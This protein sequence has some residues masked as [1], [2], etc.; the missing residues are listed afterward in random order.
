MIKFSNFKRA[1]TCSPGLYFNTYENT[2][3][4]DSEKDVDFDLDDKLKFYDITDPDD[5][6]ATVP[7]SYL[8]S[9]D[10]VYVEFLQKMN[11]FLQEYLQP[12]RVYWIKSKSLEDKINETKRIYESD[13]YD[14][15]VN[16]A[17]MDN[18]CVA[19]I[20]A[21]DI[22]NMIMYNE[23]Y[24][25]APLRK[26]ALKAYYNWNILSNWLKKYSKVLKSV[27]FVCR[28]EME[29]YEKEKY[30]FHVIEHVLPNKTR[31]DKTRIVSALG[32]KNFRN[33]EHYK[34]FPE[35][36]I[37]DMFQRNMLLDIVLEKG[38]EPSSDLDANANNFTLFKLKDGIQL[39]HFNQ[40]IQSIKA[41][42]NTKF[43][44]EDYR[45][46]PY[47]LYME[48]NTEWG[49]NPE[50]LLLY[51][52]IFG[53]DIT[54]MNG[55]SFKKN[56]YT[57]AI[58]ENNLGAEIVK[59]MDFFL[60]IPQ[61]IIVHD[62]QRVQKMIDSINN[63]KTVW[64]DYE[65]ITMPYAIMD[66]AK[67]Y[68]Q[69][70]FQI[71]IIRTNNNDIIEQ[72][73][74][75]LVYD[76]KTLNIMDYVD[77]F[78]NLYWADAEKY[79]VFNKSFENTRNKEMIKMI[80]AKF[81]NEEFAKQVMDKYGLTLDDL[82]HMQQ[83]IDIKTFD[84]ANFYQYINEFKVPYNDFDLSLIFVKH[85]YLKHSIKKLE[86]HATSQGYEFKHKIKPY[87]TLEIKNGMLAM[88]AGTNRLLNVHKD[89]LWE[90]IEKNLKIY[91]H[92]DVMAMLM[93]FEMT[94]YFN[95]NY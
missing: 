37:I 31:P 17:Y 56:V 80:E 81:S 85:L 51:E 18:D 20:Y 45:T 5:E 95:E 59:K 33:L 91:C 36:K 14:V 50:L 75:D 57:K 94:K 1:L 7:D 15:I 21:F 53:Y 62:H 9:V 12:A 86:A 19:N 69:M 39:P 28:K 13:E 73:S 34:L 47:D 48:N 65:S 25:V 70:V 40:V 32:R 78:N 30:Y 63:K 77:L 44:I 89:N 71:S 66:G 92:N 11:D 76:P 58:Q 55:T 64:Y 29:Y 82:K 23:Y 61:E 67:P 88:E 8:V 68:Q 6:E 74:Q 93:V 24:N 38:A 35:T 84:L 83:D 10:K 2:I 72:G 16:G 87:K 27:Q 49:K 43:N 26:G 52:L 41:N 42:E 22:K 79:I 90:L 4:N 60:N 54:Q 3:N 46:R